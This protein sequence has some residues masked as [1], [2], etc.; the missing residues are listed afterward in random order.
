[1]LS[2]K[3]LE[4][5]ICG[6]VLLFTLDPSLLAVPPCITVCSRDVLA[7]SAKTS[8]LKHARPPGYTQSRFREQHYYHIIIRGNAKIT[9]RIGLMLQAMYSTALAGIE[10]DLQKDTKPHI[11][12]SA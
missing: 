9:L 5:S 10:K 6:P 8:W 2:E 1:L 3:L 4:I 7:H 11:R 12:R